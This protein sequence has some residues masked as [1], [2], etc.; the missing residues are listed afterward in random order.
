MLVI[1]LLFF[2]SIDLL[3]KKFSTG[4]IRLFFQIFFSLLSVSF[5]SINSS[6]YIN[7]SYNSNYYDQL[8]VLC[9]LFSSGLLKLYNLVAT[10]NRETNQTF[11]P[12][13]ILLAVAIPFVHIKAFI[14]IG[15]FS[16]QIARDSKKIL[17]IDK[18]NTLNILVSFFFLLNFPNPL[19]LH[20]VIYII[21][22]LSTFYT[23][24]ILLFV[25]ANSIAIDSGELALWSVRVGVGVVMVRLFISSLSNVSFINLNRLGIPKAM[26]LE[27]ALNKLRFRRS[28]YFSVSEK[29]ESVK[30]RETRVPLYTTSTTKN[31]EPLELIL[32]WSALFFICV[33]VGGAL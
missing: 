1:Y 25:L 30:L 10:E 22:L 6:D 18:M 15:I 31:F 14:A 20:L 16:F 12:S 32:F 11:F 24:N 2:L 26:M 21:L 5:L 17:L 13:L 3:L 7:N 9:A 29:L 19:E 4:H 23:K 33:V 8:V 28:S 27:R